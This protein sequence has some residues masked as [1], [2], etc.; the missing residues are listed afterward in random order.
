[1]RLVLE[2]DN[3]EPGII[4]IKES[5]IVPMRDSAIKVCGQRTHG[6]FVRRAMYIPNPDF[7]CTYILGQDDEDA[8]CIVQVKEE[9]KI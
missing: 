6:E 7:G 3:K 4:I 5:Q 8:W 2:K 9:D 1:M